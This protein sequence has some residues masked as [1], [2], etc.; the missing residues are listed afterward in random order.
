M[1]VI[2]AGRGHQQVVA[3]AA[4]ET[5]IAFAA[6]QHIIGRRADDGVVAAA[7]QCGQAM[8]GHIVHRTARIACGH[9]PGTGCGDEVIAGAGLE[10]LDPRKVQAV[11]IGIVDRALFGGVE[12]DAEPARTRRGAKD[13]LV[14]ARRIAIGVGVVVVVPVPADI[15]IQCRAA[16]VAILVPDK[17]VGTRAFPIARSAPWLPS[18]QS[19]PE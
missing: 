5:V 7:A 10:A 14:A 16:A 13:Q 11:A 3:I 6:V 2:V 8:L 12:K 18:I 19:S 9:D 1:A 15:L 4:I 17:G